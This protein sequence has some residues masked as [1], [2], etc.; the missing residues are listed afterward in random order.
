MNSISI[1]YFINGCFKVCLMLGCLA[2]GYA[3][4]YTQNYQEVLTNRAHIEVLEKTVAKQELELQ[5]F[6][7]HKVETETIK[8]ALAELSERI[9]ILEKV[10]AS[11]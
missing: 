11:K 10:V 4:G 3:L 2:I 7:R 9:A 1:K 8:H 5:E 6:Q